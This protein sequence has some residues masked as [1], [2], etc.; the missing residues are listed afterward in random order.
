MYFVENDNLETK[1]KKEQYKRIDQLEGKYVY[2]PTNV[3][4][5]LITTAKP[6][7]YH[8]VR[9]Y[10]SKTCQFDEVDYVQMILMKIPV[11]LTKYQ[12]QE[13]ETGFSTYLFSCMRNFFLKTLRKEGAKKREIKNPI[14][15][16][17]TTSQGLEIKEYLSDNV[18]VEDKYLSDMNTKKIYDYLYDRFPQT[19]QFYIAYLEGYKVPAISKIYGCSEKIILSEIRK[20]RYHMKKRLEISKSLVKNDTI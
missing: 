18:D 6:M 13:N 15:M 2:D 1:I 10:Y 4:E 8:I 7:A 17:Q 9:K 19:A 16:E 5:E 3:V 11:W 12:E 14:Y 20:I